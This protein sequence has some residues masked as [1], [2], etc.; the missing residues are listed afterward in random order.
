MRL[1]IDL[2]PRSQESAT[3]PYPEPDEAIP[4][5]SYPMPFKLI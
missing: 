1:T 5:V 4:H 3:S 2:T